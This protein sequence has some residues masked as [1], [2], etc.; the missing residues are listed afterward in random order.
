VPY[1]A[2]PGSSFFALIS[3]APKHAHPVTDPHYAFKAA[4]EVYMILAWATL[5]EVENMSVA[6]AVW[7]LRPKGLVSWVLMTDTCNASCLVNWDQEGHGS[8]PAWTKSLTNSI[9]TEKSW[10][11]WHMPVI[12][13]MARSLKWEDLSLVQSGQKVSPYLQNNQ[14]KK[15]WRCGSRGRAP[16]YNM[17]FICRE[18]HHAFIH[19]IKIEILRHQHERGIYHGS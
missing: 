1:R 7:S 10:A 4:N 13:V 15:G 17:I 5:V 16:A 6:E 2:E 9:S 19:S 18:S 12:P 8:R 11:W 3:V 14:S